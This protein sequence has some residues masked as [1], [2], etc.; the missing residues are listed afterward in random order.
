MYAVCA[1]WSRFEEGTCLHDFFTELHNQWE[2]AGKRLEL[3]WA[4]KECFKQ[5]LQVGP[6]NNTPS[7]TV[8]QTVQSLVAFAWTMSFTYHDATIII[9]NGVL[10]CHRACTCYMAADGPM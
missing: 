8:P 3:V 7:N 6:E 5:I 4:V 2:T 10:T 1:F 9:T